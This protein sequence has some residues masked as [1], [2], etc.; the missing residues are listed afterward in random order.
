MF[1]RRREKIG[2]GAHVGGKEARV[3]IRNATGHFDRGI[4]GDC[5]A[6]GGGELVHVLVGEED[7]QTE[8]ACL[9]KKALESLIEVLGCLVDDQVGRRPLRLR[10]GDALEGGVERERDHVAAEEGR[11]IGFEEGLRAC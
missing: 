5:G 9:S 4:R 10:D 7:T 6:Q 2:R 8:L 1:A 3:V 11:C